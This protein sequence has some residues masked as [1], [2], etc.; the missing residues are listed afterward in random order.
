MPIDLIT[1][2]P[3][4]G[5]TLRMMQRLL[6]ESAKTGS[7]RRYLV[8]MGIEGLEPGLV[9]LEMPDGKQ[10]NLVNFG[11]PGIC[12]CHDGTGQILENEGLKRKVLDG[13]KLVDNPEWQIEMDAGR[14]HAHV[15]PN[16]ALIFVDEAWKSFGHMTDARGAAVPTHVTALAEHRHRGLDFIW[17]TQMANQIY[18]FVRGLIGSHTHVARRFGSKVCT[19][20][21]WGQLCEDVN[22]TTNREKAVEETWVHPTKTVG[23]KYHSATE[24]TIKTKL[25][26]K[27]WLIPITAIGAAVMIYFSY[28]SLKPDNFAASLN[29]Q[30][31]PESGVAAPASGG[32]SERPELPTDAEGWAVYLAPVVPG[33]AFTAPVFAENL[34]VT[35]HP[36]TICYIVGLPGEDRCKCVTEQATKARVTESICRAIVA[37]GVYD[38]FK[39]EPDKRVEPVEQSVVTPV[40]LVPA[41]AK[42]AP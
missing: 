12:T 1:G 8:N 3:G 14:P 21:T 16:G 15:I 25:P 24:H 30:P 23:A 35:S 7:D 9:D 11:E 34:E 26:W 33:L 29:G 32:G 17:T 36:Q 2:Q 38:P 27:I 20:Y 6:A 41:I 18:P 10:W 37:D 4:N 13:R 28:Q 19:V 42:S 5:K 40:D 31:V 39:P 22:T